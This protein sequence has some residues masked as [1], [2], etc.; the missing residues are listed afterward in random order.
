MTTREEIIKTV[1]TTD[2]PQLLYDIL[3]FIAARQADPNRPPRGSYAAFM[4]HGGTTSQDDADEMTAIINKEFNN[5][6]GEW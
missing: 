3:N 1:A 5:I 4:R 2:D 6:E